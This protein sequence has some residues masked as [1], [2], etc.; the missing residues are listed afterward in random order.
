MIYLD[1]ASTTPLSDAALE[2]LYQTSRQ[3]YGNPSSTHRHG[4]Q[5][6]QMLREAKTTIA[7]LLE[8]DASQLIMTSGGSEANNLAIRGYALANES[9]GKHLITTAI[10][11]HS[12]LRTV[13]DLV[14]NWGFEATIIAPQ[15]GKIT[16]DQIADA[17]RP[18]TI[19]VSTM[20]TNNE[21][22][23]TLPI[24]AIGQ[25][26]AD[27]QALFHV[28]AVQTM[29]KLPISPET[30]GIDLLS[31]SA[32]KFHGPKG[33][34]F[35]YSNTKKIWPL[36]LGGDQEEKRRA[37]TENLAAIAAMARAL[38]DSLSHWEQ[39][40]EQVRQLKNLLF[41]ELSPLAFYQNGGDDC[42]P[43]LVNIGFPGQLNE[44]LLMQLDLA[45]ISVSSGSAC[46]AGNIEPS[47]VLEAIYG[48]G[49]PQ[50]KESIRLSFSGLTKPEE[51]IH[52]T[53]T[54]KTI[55]G[56]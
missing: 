51:I 1:N 44:R 33:I 3:V 9:K 45:G 43:Y 23:L 25:L 7:R 42:L 47:H 34:G 27:H 20:H 26:L 5:A 22:G 2:T 39:H 11:H 29:G 10:E 14:T 15:D 19:L 46:T 49:E 24:Q 13:E 8:V 50:L 28:D 38:E 52:F 31:A 4:R 36:I 6:S 37:G 54:I 48:P 21:T 18:D 41:K 32:H 35:L 53:Q 56:D 55:L 30:L 17:L 12:V 16:S 40:L